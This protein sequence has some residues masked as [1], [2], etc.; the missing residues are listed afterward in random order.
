M[1]LTAFVHRYVGIGG[2]LPKTLRVMQLTTVLLLGLCLQTAAT[3]LSQTVTFSGKDVPLE[4]VFSTIKEQTG[5]FV[6]YKAS[7][8]N[9]AKPVTIHEENMPLEEFLSQVLKNQPLDFTIEE[10]TVFIKWKNEVYPHFALQPVSATLSPPA[11]INLSGRVTNN[12]NEPLEGVSVVVKGTKTG[13]VTDAGGRFQLSVPSANHVELVFSFVGYAS[14]TIKT[15]SQTVFNIVMEE[16][17]ADLSDVVVVGYGTQRKRDL[18]GAVSTISEKD[19]QSRPVPSFADALQGRAS[20]VQVAQTGGDLNGRFSIKIRGAGSV[21]SSVQPLIV[22]DG[23]PLSSAEFSTINPQDIVSMNILKDASA[24]AIYGARASNGVVIITTR[25]G[26]AGETMITF[27]ANT[28]VEK[29]AKMYKVLTSEQ[30]RKLFVSAFENTGRDP[31]AFQ[32][33]NDSVWQINTDWQKLGT[34]A[35]WR[36]NYDVSVS[37]GKPNNQFTISGGYLKRQGVV[38]GTDITNYYF[39]ANN[40]LAIGK[41]LKII[42]S[43]SGNYQTQNLNLYNDAFNTGGN[44]SYESLIDTH[45]YIPAYDNNGNLFNVNTSADPYFGQN[46]NPLIN[47]LMPTLTQSNTRLLGSVRANYEIVNGLT[48][49][50]NLGGD[51]L[52]ER[53]YTYL[54]VYKIGLSSRSQG[55]AANASNQGLNWVADATLTYK[56][57]FGL[58]AITALIGYSAQQFR[59]INNSTTGTGTINNSLNQLSNQTTFSASGSDVSVG[60]LSS[61]VRLN[62]GYNGKYL[63]TATVRRDGSSRF[64]LSK[65]Y[66]IFP[67]GSLAWNI[68]KEN[69]FKS[70]WID[71]LKLRVSYGLTG[72]QNIPDFAFITKAGASLYTFGNT[73]VVGNSLLNVGVPDLQWESAKQIDAGLDI[74]L[75]NGR[76][77]STIDYYNKKSSKLLVQVPLPLTAG[78]S[79]N[80]TVN[81]GSVEN[82]GFEFFVSSVNLVGK[83]KWSTDFNISTNKNKV[84]N[85]GTNSAGSPLQIPGYTIGLPQDFANLTVA[86]QPVGAFYMYKFI[87]IWQTA[88]AS[89]A[90]KYGAVPG[91]VRY[92]DLNNNE[93]LDAGDKT[94]VGSPQPTYY[95]GLNNTFSYSN[96]SL[97]VFMSYSGG[98]K[99]YNGI[100]NLN[101]RSV[102][103]NH[104]LAEVADFWTPDNPSNSVPRASQGGNSTALASRVSTRYLENGSYL[105]MSNISLSYNIP[106]AQL[107]RLKMENARITLGG[108]NLFTITK[109]KGLDPASASQGD[110]TSGGLDFTPYP[111]TRYYYLSLSLTF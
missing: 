69:F 35:A 47:L 77:T 68:S 81:L 101:A 87:G 59:N 108:S 9:K 97:S 16:A 42:S 93:Q 92:A 5:Y 10:N 106:T 3:G 65:Q 88:Q 48:L 4:K 27:N 111:P 76:I 64:G 7:Q 17:V 24:T 21:T 1:Q 60:L 13:T 91:D 28:G 12:N 43:F 2:I 105:K 44:G 102:P 49:S 74:I 39:R 36:Q 11:D 33:P 84:L 58:N 15:G 63:A 75:L 83:F 45:T 107:K 6:S 37:G 98:N 22:V 104:Q 66:G 71:N 20:G 18:T 8:V 46:T 70:K 109:Y 86:G 62:Y 82:K 50:G 72:N 85:I 32:N 40:D 57:D 96:F 26:K 29:I 94:F 23:V 51:I 110:L 89:E 79:Q 54:P 41:K 80:P 25:R 78:V 103:Y 38:K 100:R 61:F 95:G 34:R 55:S 31:S 53:D 52:T 99:I 90:A 56:K 19:I 73:I 14:Q 30:Q 67:S